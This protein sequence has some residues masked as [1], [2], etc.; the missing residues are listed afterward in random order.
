MHMG[1]DFILVNISL[2]F[3]DDLSATEMEVVISRIDKQIKQA[4]KNVKR[5]FIEAEARRDGAIDHA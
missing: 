3:H 1:P 4:Y 5:I 2:D